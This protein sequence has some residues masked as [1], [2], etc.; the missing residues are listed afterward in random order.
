[1]TTNSMPAVLPAQRKDASAC[2]CE[3]TDASTVVCTTRQANRR[4]RH[5]A[6]SAVPISWLQAH[7]HEGLG[8]TL[9]PCIAHIAF[10]GWHNMATVASAQWGICHT[11][12]P[13][14]NWAQRGKHPA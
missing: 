12:C 11:V 8:H 4:T 7:L 14:E 3:A 9:T 1:M 5:P 2:M 10:A 6:S 13:S